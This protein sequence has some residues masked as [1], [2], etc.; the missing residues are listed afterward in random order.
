[1]RLTIVLAWGLEEMRFQSY[2]L[3]Q[4]AATLTLMKTRNT[5]PVSQQP[6]DSP[7]CIQWPPRER[8]EVAESHIP[9]QPF[10]HLIGHRASWSC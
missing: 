10:F 4:I 5:V 9:G 3:L 2:L 1:M 7:T 8:S 6:K